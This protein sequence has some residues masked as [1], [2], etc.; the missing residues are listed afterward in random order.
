ML[1]FQKTEIYR[2][3]LD[4]NTLVGEMTDE[5]LSPAKADALRALQKNAQLLLVDLVH[6]QEWGGDV[7]DSAYGCAAMLDVYR[8]A[9]IDL[10]LCD[11]IQ[12]QIDQ[13]V[14]LASQPKKRAR[15]SR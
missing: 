10:A 9:G 7:L 3:A 11:R 2:A 15:G 13:I 4:L 1:E 5:G 6:S 14:A 12:D 8:Q